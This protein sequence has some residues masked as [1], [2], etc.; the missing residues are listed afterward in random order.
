MKL[1]ENWSAKGDKIK[2]D[3]V[4]FKMD[5]YFFLKEKSVKKNR[6]K[7]ISS[8]CHCSSSHSLF[9]PK[10]S[11]SLL[12]KEGKNERTLARTYVPVTYIPLDFKAKQFII[13]PKSPEA[14]FD[15]K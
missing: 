7:R 5:F 10:I 1:M 15:L 2:E 8:L 14:M 6:R 9:K 13:G 3:G 4:F 12:K 11:L